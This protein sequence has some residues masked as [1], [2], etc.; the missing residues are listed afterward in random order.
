[1]D[2]AVEASFLNRFRVSVGAYN[3]LTSD[4]LAEVPFPSS[5]GVGNQYTNNGCVRNRGLEFEFD[6]IV[7]QNKDWKVQVG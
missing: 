2:F 3:K 6:A 4:L 5:A 7:F 1:M